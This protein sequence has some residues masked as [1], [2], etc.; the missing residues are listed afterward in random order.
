VI[1]SPKQVVDLYTHSK[2]PSEAMKEA[3]E[4]RLPLIEICTGDHKN[5]LYI[6]MTANVD[7]DFL[8]RKWCVDYCTNRNWIV[9]VIGM[10]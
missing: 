10:L 9:K 4:E 6:V 2:D 3:F 5:P 1:H 7:I 8:K